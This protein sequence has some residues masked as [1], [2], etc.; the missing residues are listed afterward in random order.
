MAAMAALTAACGAA[1][2]DAPQV[3]LAVY[4]PAEQQEAAA[5]LPP[6]PHILRRMIEDYG[7][8]RAA[9]RAARE[10]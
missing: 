9:L 7:A 5:A 2:S 1:T 6:P 4:T 8:L 10:R 3:R